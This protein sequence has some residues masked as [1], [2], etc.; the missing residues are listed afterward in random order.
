[1]T[2]NKVKEKMI[3]VWEGEIIKWQCIVKKKGMIL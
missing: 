1:M 2:L 3:A